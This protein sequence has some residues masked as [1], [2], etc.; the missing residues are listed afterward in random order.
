MTKDF[1][2]LF[3]N[4]QRLIAPNGLLVFVEPNALFLNSIRKLWYKLDARFDSANESAINPYMIHELHGASFSLESVRFFG[5]PGF[6]VIQNSMILGIPKFAK[7]L[8][9]SVLTRFDYWVSKFQLKRGLP[10]F[11][12]V[13]RR[14]Q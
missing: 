11:F 14:E 2:G 8:L 12:S 3:F 7:R 5:G 4:I 9:A 6:F 10:A 13:W 1:N